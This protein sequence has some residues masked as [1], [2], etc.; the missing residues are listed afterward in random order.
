MPV[1]PQG[2]ASRLRQTPARRKALAQIASDTSAS[3]SNAIANA[4]STFESS[5]GSAWS[6]SAMPLRCGRL[7]NPLCGRRQWD[8]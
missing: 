6:A 5:A 4:S 3:L 8:G 7:N 1:T 2:R